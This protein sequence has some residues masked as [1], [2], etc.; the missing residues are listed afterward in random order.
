MGRS[1]LS[2]S[3]GGAHLQE[4][5]WIN[6]QTKA[7]ARMHETVDPLALTTIIIKI[8]I[9]VFICNCYKTNN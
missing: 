3:D 5:D 7:E 9:I 4:E 1:W 8:I 2:W 6:I